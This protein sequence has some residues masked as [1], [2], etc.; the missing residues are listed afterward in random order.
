MVALL[1]TVVVK[2]ATG[3]VE[4]VVTIVVTDNEEL[5]SCVS[6]DVDKDEV[7]VESIKEV[8]DDSD[9]SV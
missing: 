8:V 6:V 2:L 1:E 4:V 9:C 3:E 7:V 5:K